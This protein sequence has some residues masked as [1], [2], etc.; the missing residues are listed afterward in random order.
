VMGCCANLRDLQSIFA[1]DSYA[2]P[3]FLTYL[4][5]TTFMLAMVPSLTRSGWRAWRSGLWDTRVAELKRKYQR[6]GW[7]AVS[8][9]P[10]ANAFQQDER[11]R[12]SKDVENEDSDEG[13]GLLHSG[14]SEEPDTRAGTG[15]S[16]RKRTHLAL[17]PTASLAFKFCLLWFTAN[18]FAMACLQYTTVASTTI[19]TSTSSIWTLL[20]GAVTR[21]EHFTWRKLFGVLASLFG[22]ML[23]SKIDMG[24]SDPPDTSDTTPETRSALTFLATRAL[25]PFPSKP[26]SELLLGDA[27]ALLSAILYGIYT[28]MLKRTTL[29][30]LPL[31]LNMP[32]FFGL[33]GFFNFLLLLPLFPILHYTGIETFMLPPSARIWWILVLNSV[34]ALASDI[35]WAYA[36]VLTSPLVV[37]VGLSLTIPLSLVGEM[38]IQ[39]RYEGWVY[40]LGAGVVVGSFVF[41]DR[42][43]R[44]DEVQGPMAGGEERER[45]SLERRREE[46]VIEGFEDR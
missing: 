10:G 31:E 7:R 17:V 43:E 3:F 18:Y 13:E 25:D 42:E 29:L 44:G 39:G 15:D 27:L 1:D 26:P 45:E 5:G 41:V 23:I 11:D 36:M 12:L 33:V 32:L 30:A 28:V 24:S 4:N 14:A 21:T 37:T 38:V 9:D 16:P 6:G 2:K 35:A 46:E 20:I 22:I 19:L 40:W 34:S 8:Q